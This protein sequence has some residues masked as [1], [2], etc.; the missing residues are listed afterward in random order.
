[1]QTSDYDRL[2]VCHVINDE[3]EL[4]Y[5]RFSRRLKDNRESEWGLFD[6][7]Y[8]L[9]DGH[10]EFHG[11]R[12]VIR[13]VEKVSLFEVLFCKCS[14][15]SSRL[16]LLQNAP[17]HFIGRASVFPIHFQPLQPLGEDSFR[18]VIQFG[19]WDGARWLGTHVCNLIVSGFH[20]NPNPALKLVLRGLDGKA[21]AEGVPKRHE[22]EMVHTPSVVD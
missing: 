3:W 18:V 13:F 10:H 17:E 1:M 21:R 8:S 6:S 2:S 12:G 15:G 11:K 19:L 5:T 22:C 20:R 4:R 9:P 14:E 7:V 16:G